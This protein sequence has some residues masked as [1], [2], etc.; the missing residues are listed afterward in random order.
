M[1]YEQA[2]RVVLL[3]RDRLRDLKQRTVLILHSQMAKLSE[4]TFDRSDRFTDLLVDVW[5]N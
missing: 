3:S 1:Y 4:L 5:L 2:T